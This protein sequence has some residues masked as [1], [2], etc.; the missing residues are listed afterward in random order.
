MNEKR[1]EIFY[2]ERV[3][4]DDKEKIVSSEFLSC[5][6]FKNLKKSKINK[7]QS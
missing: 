3:E 5:L 7:N 4:R 2:V 1:E 6:W